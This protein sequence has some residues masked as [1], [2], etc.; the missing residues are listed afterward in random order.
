ME[1]EANYDVIIAGAGPAGSAL[2]QF[3]GRDG[4]NVLLLDRAKFPRDKTCGDAVGGKSARVM[5]ELGIYGGMENLPHAKVTGVLFSSPKGTML[6][7]PFPSDKDGKIVPGYVCKRMYYDNF[8]FE[9]AKKHKSVTVIENFKVTDVVF[10][11]GRAIGLKGIDLSTKK[12]RSF[13]AKII[14]GADGATSVVAQKAGVVVQD[15]RHHCLSVRAYYK[16][17]K[18]VTPNIELHFVKSVLPG[19]F[20]IF[21]SDNGT[22]NVG[23]GMITKDVKDHKVKLPEEMVRIIKEEP[24]FKERF[25]GAEL[26]G[27]IQGWSLPFGSIHRKAHGDGYVLLGDAASLIDPFSGE[28]IGNATTSAMIAAPVIVKALKS[29]DYSAAALKEYED[30]LWAEIGP[31]LNNSYQL[32]K[33]GKIQFLLNFLIDKAARKPELQQ[34]ISGML[35]NEEAKQQ[36]YD[37][38]FYLK[39]I[40][41]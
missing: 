40:F 33:A 39:L 20:W 12:E 27:N 11:N 16:G 14:A 21:P 5:K 6:Q 13:G 10:D 1:F 38:I 2:A 25:A 29:G 18:D 15:D 24:L 3:L 35:S 8:M 17:V 26:I 23:L 41:T 36:L 9:H 4:V 37:P 32:Q 22:V 31:E 30:K 7:I 19:Y 34:A 28:G